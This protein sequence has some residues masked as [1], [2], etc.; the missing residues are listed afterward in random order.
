MVDLNLNKFSKGI[1]YEFFN[2]F[3]NL[4]LEFFYLIILSK[5][6]WFID[7]DYMATTKTTIAA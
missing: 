7:T 4:T 6:K 5:N 1:Q 3:K 2:T